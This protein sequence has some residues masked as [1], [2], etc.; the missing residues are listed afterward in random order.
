MDQMLE[1]QGIDACEE[2]Q[3]LL[4]RI[5][6]VSGGNRQ[7]VNGS[8]TTLGILKLVGDGLEIARIQGSIVS[9]VCQRNRLI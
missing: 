9:L 3:L 2:G 6:S 8:Q 5:F 7:F 1:K 4:K